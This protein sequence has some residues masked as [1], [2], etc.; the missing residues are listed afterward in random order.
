MAKGYDNFFNFPSGAR[1]AVREVKY[2]SDIRKVDNHG[3][4]FEV[5]SDSFN[6]IECF[7]NLSDPT[8][9]NLYDFCKSMRNEFLAQH[10]ILNQH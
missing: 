2:I 5:R 4:C 1:C 7:Y 9:P 10:A 8:N 6:H 3:Y